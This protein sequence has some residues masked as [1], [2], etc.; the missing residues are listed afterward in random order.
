MHGGGGDGGPEPLRLNRRVV[1][2]IALT[3]VVFLV[4]FVLVGI[5]GVNAG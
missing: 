5:A 4:L 3:L 2:G 1:L